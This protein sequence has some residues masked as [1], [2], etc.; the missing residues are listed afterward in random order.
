MEELFCC[1]I[2]LVGVEFRVEGIENGTAAAGCGER[3]IGVE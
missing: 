1:D 2:D 3:V